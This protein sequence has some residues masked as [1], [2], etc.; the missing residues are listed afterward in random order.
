MQSLK[1]AE[2]VMC[3]RAY[4]VM[5]QM[6]KH[7]IHRSILILYLLPV[8]TNIVSFCKLVFLLF[9]SETWNQPK[10][11]KKVYDLLLKI[12]QRKTYG[13]AFYQSFK[14]SVPD[15][16]VLFLYLKKLPVFP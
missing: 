1:L 8:I 14:G 2:A 15:P 4:E 16:R 13:C 3:Y 11:Y 12:Y 7:D 10:A 5:T 6:R 9:C